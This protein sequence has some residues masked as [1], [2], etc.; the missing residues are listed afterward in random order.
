EQEAEFDALEAEHAEL[1]AKRPEVAAAAMRAR[2]AG[3]PARP[4]LTARRAGSNPPAA[5]K[6]VKE[7][8]EDDPKRGFKDHREF[9]LTV[10]DAGARG[11]TDDPRLKFMAAGADEHSTVSDPYGGFL[12]PIGFSPDIMKV[13]AE[14]DP[15]GG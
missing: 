12:L 13:M 2:V 8:F 15:I 4:T 7:G 6:V 1:T 11:Y 3:R 10:M 5:P 9:L 14:A